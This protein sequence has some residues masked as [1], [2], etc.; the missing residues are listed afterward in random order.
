MGSEWTPC[1]AIPGAITG[2]FPLPN[3]L[4]CVHSTSNAALSLQ[5]TFCLDLTEQSSQSIHSRQPSQAS[6]CNRNPPNTQSF[7]LFQGQVDV[8]VLL[9]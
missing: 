1:P 9:Q 2:L 7:G 5:L 3:S 6:M 8:L 4:H